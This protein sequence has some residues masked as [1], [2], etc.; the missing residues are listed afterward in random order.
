MCPCLIVV[1]LRIQNCEILIS[2]VKKSAHQWHFCYNNQSGQ[3][4]WHG[5]WFPA[6]ASV[7]DESKREEESQRDESGLGRGAPRRS[8]RL[9][10]EDCKDG[11]F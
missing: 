11:K 4:N 9:E 6:Q 5:A 7:G 3:S 1:L 2:V 10:G 8:D